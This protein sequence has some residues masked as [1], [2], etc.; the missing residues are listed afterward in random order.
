M[1]AGE[2]LFPKQVPPE[3]Q[4]VFCLLTLSLPRSE[5]PYDLIRRTNRPITG[6][7]QED[8]RIAPLLFLSS[9][10]C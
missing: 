1:E 2:M 5:G 7:P 9:F 3:Q 8:T 10:G 4:K 6:L